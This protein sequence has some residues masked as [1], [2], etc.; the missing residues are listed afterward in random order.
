MTCQV[1]FFFASSVGFAVP[2]TE[3]FTLN[4]FTKGLVLAVGPTICTKIMS[5]TFAYV[6]FPYTRIYLAFALPSS[7]FLLL[8]AVAVHSHLILC[9][10]R[11]M[12]YTSSEAKAR[13]RQAS[14]VTHYLHVQP[15]QLLVGMAMVARGEFA[16]IVAEIA[17]A[18]PV[19]RL[20][21][22]MG[23]TRSIQDVSRTVIMNSPRV[24]VCSARR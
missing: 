15:Q 16:Y 1:R 6:F 12:H 11:Y 2:L 21:L 19:C 4:A 9:C 3:M 18:R 5:G 17:Q 10:I 8:Y 24:T 14:W 7:I 13:A 23:R 20:Y 22:L